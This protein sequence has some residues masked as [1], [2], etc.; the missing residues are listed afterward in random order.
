MCM[1]YSGLINKVA[2]RHYVNFF[3]FSGLRLDVAFRRLCAKLYLKAETQQVDRILEEFSRRYWET[4]L[5]TVYGSASECSTDL[6]KAIVTDLFDTGVVHAVSYSLLLLNTDLHVA[7][8]NSRM[9]RNQFVRNTLT[10]I[11]MQIRPT[12]HDRAS[13]PDLTHDDGSSVRNMGSDGSDLGGNT[14]RSRG[15][16]SG[17]VTSW[18]SISRD[19]LTTPVMNNVSSPQLHPPHSAHGTPNGSTA[20]IL[21]PRAKES[22]VNSVVYG[23]NFDNDMENL[24]KASTHRLHLEFTFTQAI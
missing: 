24:L 20:S 10:A 8:L 16:R 13:T 17:S 21:E 12:G 22:S 2:L 19:L 3:D 4:N 14:A 15:T 5:G 1:Y 6:H 7:E 9:S 11:Q 23:R 18:N